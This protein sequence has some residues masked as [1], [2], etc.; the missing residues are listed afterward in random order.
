MTKGYTSRPLKAPGMLLVHHP[1]QKP[2]QILLRHLKL[3]VAQCCPLICPGQSSARLRG[4]C[5]GNVISTENNCEASPP[6]IACQPLHLPF[7]A[8]SRLHAG[9]QLRYELGD[10]LS[11][12]HAPTCNGATSAIS[13]PQVRQPHRYW[14]LPGRTALASELSLRL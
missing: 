3:L 1:D 10:D 13:R 6:G 14:H 9:I 8:R 7:K 2:F 12:S 11:A 5:V 4:L